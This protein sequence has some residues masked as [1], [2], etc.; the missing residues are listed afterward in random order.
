MSDF[1]GNPATDVL[2]AET[3]LFGSPM[4]MAEKLGF[5]APPA[6]FDEQKIRQHFSSLAL[7]FIETH[8]PNLATLVSKKSI[9][10]DDPDLAKQAYGLG[11]RSHISLTLSQIHLESMRGASGEDGKYLTQVNQ[12]VEKINEVHDEGEK[13]KEIFQR[14]D[15]EGNIDFK[16]LSILGRRMVFRMFDAIRAGDDRLNQDRV[17]T[18]NP[19]VFY[20]VVEKACKNVPASFEGI[21]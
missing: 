18:L 17:L 12:L 3:P 10:K 2:T 5:D 21:R 16:D 11:L 7:K 1:E 14:V 20:E 6:G 4:L 8:N 15:G 13:S 19:K 9:Q